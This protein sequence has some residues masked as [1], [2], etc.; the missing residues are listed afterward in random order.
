MIPICRSF[1]LI[2]LKWIVIDIVVKFIVVVIV[3]VIAKIVVVIAKIVMVIDIIK[4]SI[5]ILILIY[6]FSS[7]IPQIIML[8]IS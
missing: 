2:L 6:S 5:T 7:F 4:T 8:V 3:I 1:Y